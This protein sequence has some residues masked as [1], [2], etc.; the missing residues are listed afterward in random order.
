MIVIALLLAFF[1]L[2]DQIFFKTYSP[3]WELYLTAISVL[4]FIWQNFITNILYA[5]KKVWAA[6]IYNNFSNLLKTV[7][8]LM[9]AY[10][11]HVTVGSVIFTFGI[12]GPVIFFIYILLEKSITSYTLWR[13]KLS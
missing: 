12:V 7:I 1:P 2:L 3:I 13:A 5:A 10:T 11:H 9:L 6:N 8:L 4:L